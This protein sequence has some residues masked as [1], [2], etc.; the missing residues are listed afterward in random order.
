MDL[1]DVWSWTP[2][3]F[4]VVFSYMQA[5]PKSYFEAAA[6]DGASKVRS[7]LGI[8]L[9]ISLP[10]IVTAAIIRFIFAFR[11]F[12]GIWSLAGGG[13]GNGSE[14]LSVFLYKQ[15][16]QN[17]EISYG[18]SIGVVML[19]LIILVSRGIHPLSESRETGGFE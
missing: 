9:P 8:L 7:V 17:Q 5:I 12:G 16:F 11:S 15:A 13:P 14:I 6:I 19:I 4:M 3:I 10:G 18:A 1:I 2:F